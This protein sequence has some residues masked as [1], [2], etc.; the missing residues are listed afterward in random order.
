VTLAAWQHFDPSDTSKVPKR[1]SQTGFYSNWST[2][3]VTAEAIGFDVNT[4]LFSDH[5]AKFRWVLLKSGSAKIKFDPESDYYEYP[6]GAVFVK[7]FQHDTIPGNTASRIYWETRVLVNKKGVDS[8]NGMKSYDYWYA[9][10]YKWK[11]DG[12]EAFLVAPEGLDTSL[13]LRVN[14]QKAFRKWTF[15]SVSACNQ[16]HRQYEKNESAHQGRSVL[17][18]FTPQLKAAS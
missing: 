5:S 16:C 8:A 3:T 10:S 12:S 13:S 14:G 4:P 15:P 11:P 6:D 7:L 1:F 2:K 18:F 9:F 17:G